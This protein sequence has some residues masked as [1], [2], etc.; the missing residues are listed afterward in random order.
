MGH[1]HAS[2]RQQSRKRLL[3]VVGLASTVLLVELIVGLWTDSLVLLADAAHMFSDVAALGLALFANWFATRPSPPHATFGYYRV[4]ILM[5]AV[6][7]VILA[8]VCFFVVREAFGRLQDPPPIDALPVML[9]GFVGLLANLIAVRVLHGDAQHSLNIRGA[10]LEVLG[11]T[12]ASVAVIVS[13]VL[14]LQFGWVLADPILSLLIAVFILPR[15]FLLLRDA[16]DVLMEAAPRGI[17]LQSLKDAVLSQEGVLDLHDLHVWTITSGRVCLSA[18]VVAEAEVDRDAVIQRVNDILR[19][20][21]QLDHT[22][23]QV[24]GGDEAATEVGCDPC[25]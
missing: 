17:D 16:T 24:E 6:N 5:A 3:V 11:D 7:A 12:L 19:L 22:T 1:F 9:T 15:V 23:L 18:H 21:F 4:E 20:Q 2:A 25:P 10:Y 14:I 8:I 13:A